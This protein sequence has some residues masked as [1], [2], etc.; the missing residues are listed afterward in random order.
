MIE[1]RTR[2]RSP[3]QDHLSLELAPL[4]PEATLETEK[5][6]KRRDMVMKIAI[7]RAKSPKKRF[8]M[9]KNTEKA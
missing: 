1:R 4:L 7:Q 5:E 8:L 2:K 6:N 9:T 3:A